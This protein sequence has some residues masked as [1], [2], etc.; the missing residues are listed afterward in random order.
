MAACA[1]SD[2]KR[3]TY[4]SLEGAWYFADKQVTGEIW[5]SESNG[6]QSIDRKGYFSFETFSYVVNGASEIKYKSTS[7]DLI[8]YVYLL[9]SNGTN[10]NELYL[11]DGI[12]N[13]TFTEITFDSFVLIRDQSLLD[14]F[15]RQ[16]IMKRR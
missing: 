2:P 11:L 6:I 16:I 13:E 12:I 15:D 1:D 3:D 7:E 4:S 14:N 9:S 8:D 10:I 5:I